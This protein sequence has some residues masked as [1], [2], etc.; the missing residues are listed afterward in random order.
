MLSLSVDEIS[1]MM[2]KKLNIRNM[3]VIELADESGEC[4]VQNALAA[5]AVINATEVDGALESWL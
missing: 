1:A 2:C 4:P 3:T 5:K